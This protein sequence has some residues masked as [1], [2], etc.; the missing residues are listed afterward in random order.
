MAGVHGEPLDQVIPIYF[1]GTPSRREP[2][3]ATMAPPLG[4]RGCREKAVRDLAVSLQEE[5]APRKTPSEPKTAALLL[6]YFHGSF[7]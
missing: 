1:L 2:G 7:S 6:S 4:P 5:W 3:V